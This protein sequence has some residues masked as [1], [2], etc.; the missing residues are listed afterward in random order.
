MQ[1]VISE[2]SAGLSPRVRGK[3]NGSR[4]ADRCAGS[5]PACAGE[6][7]PG[8]VGKTN[9]KVYPRVCGGNERGVMEDVRA[10]GLSPRVRGKLS[11]ASRDTIL[12]RSIPACAGETVVAISPYG[13]R[14]VYPRVCGGNP[15]IT[16]ASSRGLG[17]SPR[18]RG[19]RR[20]PP[21]MLE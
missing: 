10:A 16:R 18:V 9:A 15:G 19:K 11:D 5:I 17:L 2:V 1:L 20:P 13:L 6:T 3:R 14:E 21:P 12:V 7:S 4:R 8:I